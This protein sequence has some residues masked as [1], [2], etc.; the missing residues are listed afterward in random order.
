MLLSVSRTRARYAVEADQY[1]GF[2]EVSPVRD[3]CLGVGELE[4]FS[5]SVSESR[6]KTWGVGKER[7][8]VHQDLARVYGIK[9][10]RFEIELVFKVDL[11]EADIHGQ[12]ALAE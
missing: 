10:C 8:E 9:G 5:A 4:T 6:N 11:L 3:E 2:N 12:I 7:T 1:L